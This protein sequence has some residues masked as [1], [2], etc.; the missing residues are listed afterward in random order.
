MRDVSDSQSRAVIKCEITAQ[1]LI[2]PVM[3]ILPHLRSEIS[4]LEAQEGAG[5]ESTHTFE[6]SNPETSDFDT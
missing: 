5:S 4:I 3:S 2:F 1:C 6:I